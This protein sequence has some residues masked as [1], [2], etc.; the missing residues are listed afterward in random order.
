M[1]ILVR[2]TAS[3]DK[4]L[5]T[6]DSDK[7]S[8][9]NVD[10]SA[11]LSLNEIDE[12]ADL[13]NPPKPK[14]LVKKKTDEFTR[15]V[16]K[17]VKNTIKGSAIL[18]RFLSELFS[19]TVYT[20]SHLGR[21]LDDSFKDAS[22]LLLFFISHIR[23]VFSD[24]DVE[25]TTEAKILE[26]AAQVAKSF[27]LQRYANYIEFIREENVLT[28]KM[29][30]DLV[31]GYSY[32]MGLRD[33][34]LLINITNRNIKE[35]SFDFNLQYGVPYALND[36]LELFAKTVNKVCCI[37]SVK[38][39]LYS[40]M[41][42]TIEVSTSVVN[43]YPHARKLD[44]PIEFVLAE[45]AI[46]PIIT[47]IQKESS[48]TYTQFI[49]G[50]KVTIP[51]RKVSIYLEPVSTYNT[52]PHTVLADKNQKPVLSL[53][54]KTV[55]TQKDTSKYTGTSALVADTVRYMGMAAQ[56]FLDKN[57][58]YLRKIN[59]SVQQKE[60]DF[61][62]ED[63]IH[64]VRRKLYAVYIRLLDT[65]GKNLKNYIDNLPKVA[66]LCHE[67]VQNSLFQTLSVA[68]SIAFKV[69]R[70]DNDFITLAGFHIPQRDD[71]TLFPSKSNQESIENIMEKE[72]R[73]VLQREEVSIFFDVEL[74]DTARYLF[75]NEF[76]F[77]CFLDK[78][79]QN[80]AESLVNKKYLSV[81]KLIDTKY[82]SKNLKTDK[83]FGCLN[84]LTK[85]VLDEMYNKIVKYRFA[86][87]PVTFVFASQVD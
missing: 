82:S 44:K 46:T 73:S 43:T 35:K 38:S 33:H 34:N 27:G 22:R 41:F 84:Y 75:S 36:F 39:V 67:Y 66:E 58:T 81:Q 64:Q 19:T 9:Q 23:E 37:Y 3:S 12:S 24:Y 10:E 68:A 21:P 47:K 49:T 45:L 16:N 63:S 11:D 80:Q 30:P 77:D 76:I 87:Y 85:V 59:L 6:T 74:G 31:Q 25:E 17:A 13:I 61:T 54:V 8:L 70:F 55:S 56:E 28:T 15:N 4:S 20:E 62:I 86:N 78:V 69:K 5:Q 79:L 72:A 42:K 52:H 71:F 57:K 65:S 14:I 18:T 1:K 29:A 53:M 60:F 32:L 83:S 40:A 7:T 48:H 51:K 50:N 2:A 26:D